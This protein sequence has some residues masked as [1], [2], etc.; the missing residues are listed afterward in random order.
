M[1]KS[2]F[3]K[4]QKEYLEERARLENIKRGDLVWDSNGL[5]DYH[6]A[7]V[8]NVNVDKDY[9]D[10]IDVTRDN[11]EFRYVGFSTKSEMIEMG[12]TKESLEQEHKKYSGIIKMVMESK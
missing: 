2:K 10:V 1:K 5:G 4:I 11:K 8:K 6:P 9:V 3:E 12:F 7:I